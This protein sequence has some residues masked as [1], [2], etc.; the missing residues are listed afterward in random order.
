MSPRDFFKIVIKILALLVIVNGI[1]PAVANVFQWFG[2]DLSSGFI[3]LGLVLLFSALAYLMII[4]SDAI[5]DFFGLDKGFDTEKFNFSNIEKHYIV[6]TG[7][8]LIGLG[9]IFNSLPSLLYDAFTYF[10]SQV[11]VYSPENSIYQIEKYI[12]YQ[13]LL[14]IVVGIILVASRKLVSKLID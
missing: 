8:A 13:N 2:T 7:A 3:L 11:E 10:K 14:Y 1:I 4:Y 12:L 9:L 6:E 5:I